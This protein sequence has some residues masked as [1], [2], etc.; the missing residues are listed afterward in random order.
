MHKRIA[1]YLAFLILITAALAVQAQVV[2]VIHLGD[3]PE[4]SC[5]EVWVQDGVNLYFTSTTK[6][7]CDGGGSC[8]FGHGPEGAWLYPGRLVVD[9]GQ[10]YDVSMVEIDVED[11]CGAGC[12]R[13]FLYNGETVLTTDWND[14]TGPQTLVLVPPTKQMMAD[15]L[16]ISS[17]E[18]VVT[19][20]TIRI[21]A[22][23]LPA[24]QTSWSQVKGSYR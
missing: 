10:V 13:A 2:T 8:N 24:D 11:Y 17:C 21:Y 16:A 15:H 19:S 3:I 14:A 20:S 7:D 4:V 22:D 5:D 23:S 9:F 1:G 18:G 12:T 6:E